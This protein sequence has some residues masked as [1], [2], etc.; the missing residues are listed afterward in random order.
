V[1]YYMFYEYRISISAQRIGYDYE[2]LVY[3]LN[4]PRP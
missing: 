1:L 2:N 3:L 4:I